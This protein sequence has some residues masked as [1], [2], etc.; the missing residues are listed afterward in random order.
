MTSQELARA[1]AQ[2][3]RANADRAEK[4]KFT[5]ANLSTLPVADCRALAD[6]I[7]ARLAAGARTDAHDDLDPVRIGR[8]AAAASWEADSHYGQA[9]AIRA[10]TRDMTLHVSGAILGARAMKAACEREGSVDA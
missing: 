4:L 7:D 3:L 5:V 8:E 1:F 10:G 2:R 9:N 6:W